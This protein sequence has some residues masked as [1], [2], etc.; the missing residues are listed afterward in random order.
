MVA[1]PGRAPAIFRVTVETPQGFVSYVAHAVTVRGTSRWRAAGVPTSRRSRSCSPLGL[2]LRVWLTIVWQPAIT[3]YSDT[4]VYFQDAYAGVWSD[5][6]RTVGYGML[7]A[8]LHWISPHLLLVTIVQHLL[9]LASA[10]LMYLH[11]AHGSA[12][13][14]G[15]A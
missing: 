14:A 1:I 8:A 6:L 12:A 13:R 7:L 10:V 9:G 4:G 2:A 11:G 15:S 3:G 5:P